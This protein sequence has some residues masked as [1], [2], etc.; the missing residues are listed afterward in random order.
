VYGQSL[1]RER[2]TQVLIGKRD[3]RDEMDKPSTPGRSKEP[4]EPVSGMP[5]GRAGQSGTKSW[6]TLSLHRCIVAGYPNSMQCMQR[7]QRCN[8]PPGR[9]AGWAGWASEKLGLS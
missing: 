6:P 9:V 4:S 7:L 2:I 1:P 3:R 5:H 8:D